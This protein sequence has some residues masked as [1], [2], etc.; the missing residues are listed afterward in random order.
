MTVAAPNDSYFPIEL[1]LYTARAPYS[2]EKFKKKY[3][4]LMKQYTEWRI[5]EHIVFGSTVNV[6]NVFVHSKIHCVIRIRTTT[7]YGIHN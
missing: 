2:V 7:S 4:S 1:I 3:F 5:T 6:Q